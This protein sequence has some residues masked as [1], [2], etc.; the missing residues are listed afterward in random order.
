MPKPDPLAAALDELVEP[1][2]GGTKLRILQLFEDRPAVLDSI[3]SAR[4][5]RHLSFNQ[6]AERLTTSGEEPVSSAAVKA[7]LKRQGIT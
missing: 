6:I 4:R 2:S 3:R 7:W 5:D 1:A